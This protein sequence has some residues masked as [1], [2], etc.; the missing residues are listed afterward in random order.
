MNKM[1]QINRQ[2]LYIIYAHLQHKIERRLK[3]V[4]MPVSNSNQK[5][6]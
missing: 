2:S 6:S 3:L 5:N 1:L 4:W